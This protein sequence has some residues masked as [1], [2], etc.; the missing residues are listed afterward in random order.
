[1]K[2][3]RDFAVAAAANVGR[4]FI[5]VGAGVD[6]FVWVVRPCGIFLFRLV[7]CGGCR[8]TEEEA[9][10]HGCCFRARIRVVVC[11][12]CG[13]GNLLGV[14]CKMHPLKDGLCVRLKLDQ[15]LWRRRVARPEVC[16]LLCFDGGFEEFG[17]RVKARVGIA[18]RDAV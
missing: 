7:N 5:V 16:W 4:V 11:V 9:L 1:M 3:P 8:V 14:A 6:V 2:V 17:D 13:K 15:F 18:H 10:P 12:D